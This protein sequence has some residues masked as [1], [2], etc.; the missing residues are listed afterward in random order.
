MAFDSGVHAVSGSRAQSLSRKEQAELDEALAA[1]IASTK[2]VSRKLNLLDVSKRISVARKYL[3]SPQAVASAVGLSSEM[4]RQFSRVAKL[5]PDVK[6]LIRGG[7]ITSVDI[8][9][10]ISRL[11]QDDQFF[12]AERVGAR[13]LN[14]DDVKAVLAHRKMLP[15]LPI[16]R[17]VSQVT[18]SKNIRRYVVEFLIPEGIRPRTALSRL[19]SFFGR[20]AVLSSD[21]GCSE[22]QLTITEKGKSLLE[23]AAKSKGLSKRKL[24]DQILSGEVTSE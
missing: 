5:S 17:L 15:D 4:L 8:A 1:L 10:R 21:I 13:E 2:R 23:K 6:T 18:R 9:D 11:P 19:L 14:S 20:D 3:G 22:G 24:L 12:V 16:Q 7:K